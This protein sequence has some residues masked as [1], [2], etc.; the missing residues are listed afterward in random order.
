M[1]TTPKSPLAC[2]CPTGEGLWHL[3]G[4]AIC[5]LLMDP[6]CS[7]PHHINFAHPGHVHCQ[8]KPLR[9]TRI[10]RRLWLFQ[11]LPKIIL[12]SLVQPLV[13]LHTSSAPAAQIS[14]PP[15][16]VMPAQGP[17]PHSPLIESKLISAGTAKSAELCSPLQVHRWRWLP[18]TPSR[19]SL[20]D[21]H[22]LQTHKESTVFYHNHSS[23]NWKSELPMWLLYIK[24]DLQPP[25][26]NSKHV[27]VKH[28]KYKM[29][30]QLSPWWMSG[31]AGKLLQVLF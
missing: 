23:S 10:F 31:T 15:C 7:H 9:R 22:G 27:R 26:L 14:A 5:W 11:T 21:V 17:A 24:S 19:L 8:A 30:F 12:M 3:L 6:P 13:T 28:L 1:V 2:C 4:T 18:Q 29:Q 16:P 20:R 25:N